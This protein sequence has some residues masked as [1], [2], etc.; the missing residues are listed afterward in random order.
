MAAISPEEPMEPMAAMPPP[1]P[2]PPPVPEVPNAAHDA[3]N[4]KAVGAK[5]TYRMRKGVTMSGTC[6]KDSKGMYFDVQ[7]YRSES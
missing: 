2:P 1:P 3:C 4:S 6:Q 5:L 7:Q